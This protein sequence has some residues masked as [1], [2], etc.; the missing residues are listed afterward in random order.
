MSHQRPSSPTGSSGPSGPS[1]P[2]GQV[3]A[4][5]DAKAAN[6][7]TS[8][9]L[10]GCDEF[11]DTAAVEQTVRLEGD[12]IP[13]SQAST[14]DISPR[15]SGP[16]ETRANVVAG[17]GRRPDPRARYQS[18]REHARGGFGRIYRAHD[19]R[20]QRTV[21]LKEPLVK[22]AQV[23]A[24]FRREALMTARLQHPS[25]V[26]V[27][28]FGESA[29]GKPYYVMKLVSGQSLDGLVRQR[30]SWRE[31][32]TLLPHVI[33]VVEA[34][35]YAH[36][37]GVIHR[38][39][40]P[41]NVLVGEFGET[42]VV[43]WGLARDMRGIVP[44]LATMHER[45]VHGPQADDAAAYMSRPGRIVGTPAYMAPEQAE[46]QTVDERADVYAL[47]ATLYEVLTGHPPYRGTSFDAVI[48]QVIERP[49]IP[50]SEELC[51]E[52]P[53]DLI[54]I[55]DKAMAR[56][57]AVRYPSAKEL[58]AD[59]ERFQ[60]G[61]LVS[62]HSYSPWVLFRRWLARNRLPAL[63]TV[64][65][66]AALIV[67][68][69][70]SLHS[71]VDERNAAQRSRNELM[72]MQA[73]HSI[74]EDPT[75]AMAWLAQAPLEGPFFA[76]ALSVFRQAMAGGVARHAFLYREPVAA[77]A[78][79]PPQHRDAMS[80]GGRIGAGG[81][82]TDGAH[83]GIE[84]AVAVRDGSLRVVDSA[85][86]EEHI[87]GVHGRGYCAIEMSSD[88]RWLAAGTED[89]EIHVW[90]RDTGQLMASIRAHEGEVIALRFAE[91][92][93]LL[94]SQA[95]DGLLAGW[96]LPLDLPPTGPGE[97]LWPKGSEDPGDD[98]RAVPAFTYKVEAAAATSMDGSVL[99]LAGADRWVR[100]ISLASMAEIGRIHLPARTRQLHLL[101]ERT[102]LIAYGTDD[103][104]RLIDWAENTV[105]RLDEAPL[106]VPF[107][108]ASSPS[109]RWLAFPSE[110][111]SI[112][113]WNLDTDQRRLLRGHEDFVYALSFAADEEFLVS[114]GDDGTARVWN[115]DSA[116]VRVLRGHRDDINITAVAGDS[117]L[118]ATA[119]KDRSLRLWRAQYANSSLLSGSRK[120]I[121]SVAFA[122]A[123]TLVSAS[124]AGEIT[125]W[126]LR[127]QSREL[128]GQARPNASLWNSA[129]THQGRYAA[130]FNNAERVVEMWNLATGQHAEWTDLRGEVRNIF[131]APGGG[132][133][134]ITENDGRVVVWAPERNMH[135]V[136]K[137]ADW[138]CTTA[139]AP[140]GSQL[141]IVHP[142]HAA[143]VDLEDMRP[144][145]TIA[146]SGQ[147]RSCRGYRTRMM[148]RYS[149][150]GR[151]AAIAD[152]HRGLVVWQ[153]QSDETRRFSFGRGFVMYMA[154]SPGGDMLAVAMVDRS[155]HLIDL[156][157]GLG[158][159]QV[160]RLGVHDDAVW[161]LVFS[162]DGGRL[163]SAS[164]D[165][166][167][168]LWELSSGA[169]EVLYGH[170]DNV[171]S[172]AF[173]PDG[174]RLASGSTDGS[175]RL[176]TLDRE[177]I[178][179][180][181]ELRARIVGATTVRIDDDMVAH[182]PNAYIPADVAP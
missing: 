166:T 80:R 168:R 32:L 50:M 38:D 13:T 153:P 161:Q 15:G 48:A 6:V 49:P 18:V 23:G 19:A 179:H 12:E 43:D 106:S 17:P 165:H 169:T 87:L 21:A 144:R 10:T 39:I 108:I 175:I 59:I 164:F 76:R 44:P 86:G 148:A 72:L 141:I 155:V 7:P 34:V 178:A 159:A 60:A 128:V 8:A 71:I 112:A 124:R 16:F 98:Y 58:A 105:R 55:V 127:D 1:G 97:P 31:R 138:V 137:T 68:G 83:G 104:L 92:G 111:W 54:A 46:G 26:P 125:R 163:A 62:A 100:L 73:E 9:E 140:S 174:K 29:E 167:V 3:A 4:A 171:S 30:T 131:H 94:I 88:G 85:T 78:F 42:V 173:A 135:T 129:L 40:K 95:T 154:F 93:S 143:V 51:A 149:R 79:A 115:L 77:L 126:G 181:A 134:A 22:S 157:P 113:L 120:A 90:R 91:H 150:D 66:V 114:G 142:S 70:A 109:G 130:V 14:V 180:A 132:T 75:T 35:A 52:L 65:S 110:P 96:P 151:F 41:S 24:L 147:G 107:P 74:A 136:A 69:M 145:K 123:D 67:L 56:N 89:G 101:P 176:W 152:T 118:I 146:L 61:Q 158:A 20:L 11:A 116:Y 117:G 84:I 156:R 27:H 28:D 99:A 47:G 45:A 33:D 172:V 53:A 133:V 81:G 182:S 37:E 36:S 160:R 102:S 121:V 64:I 170:T 63:I 139:L 177:P 122:D 82:G 103:V 5:D 57:R 25:I 119:G 162:P 2:S